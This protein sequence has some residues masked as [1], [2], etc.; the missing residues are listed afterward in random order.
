MTNLASIEIKCLCCGN[1]FESRKVVSIDSLGPVTTDFFEMS[2]GQQP[3]RYLIFTCP[4]CGYTGVSSEEGPLDSQIKKFVEET[5]SPRLKEEE[6]TSGRRWEFMAI[7]SEAKGLDD[8]AIG[9]MYLRAAWLSWLDGH[10]GDEPG[11]RRNVTEYFEKA[12]NKE[13]VLEDRVYWTK[14]LIGEMYRRIGDEINAHKWFDKVME[15]ELKHQNRDFW[16]DLARQQKTEPKEYI[17]E[18]VSVDDLKKEKRSF[19]KKIFRM[20]G[21]NA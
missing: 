13:I 10:T 1:Q 11:Y 18:P 20:F 3:I 2:V 6:L 12:L 5:I 16:I 9:S 15:I 7:I 8:F 4:E 17:R 21:S 14:Y 19:L